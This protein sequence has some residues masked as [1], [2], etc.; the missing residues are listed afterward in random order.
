MIVLATNVL[1]RGAAV[2]HAPLDAARTA[3]KLWWEFGVTIFER[4]HEDVVDES[5]NLSYFERKSA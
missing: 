1:V 2:Q 5:K 4:D 3:F